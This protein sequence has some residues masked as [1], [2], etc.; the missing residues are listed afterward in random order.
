MIIIAFIAF[1]CLAAIL[2]RG[3]GGKFPSATKKTS[4]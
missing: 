1:F 3:E 2:L 4:N